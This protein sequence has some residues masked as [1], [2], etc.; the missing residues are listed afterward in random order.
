MQF[1]NLILTTIL[2]LCY[3]VLWLIKRK[4]LLKTE[5]IDANVL[6]KSTKPTQRYFSFLEK[7]MSISIVIIIILHAFYKDKIAITNYINLLD[8]HTFK[9]IGFTL[10][11]S[12]LTICRIAQST[13]GKSWR[14]GI[15]DNA[16]PGLIKNGI[17][18]YM[19]NPT[20]TGLFILCVG[21]FTINPTI[22]YSYW[23]LVFFIMIDFQVRCEEEYLESKYG[24][25][26]LT[27]C[28]KT[29]RYL[30]YIY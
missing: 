18:K 12:G 4:E 17:Y 22:L 24:D 15:D 20:Y 1:Q 3:L 21:I 27:Y 30:P 25:E 8:Y 7:I 6:Q 19:R 9:I 14:V 11:L 26:Y 10:G 5:G 28:K 2:F 29:K 16:K 13:I 23:I